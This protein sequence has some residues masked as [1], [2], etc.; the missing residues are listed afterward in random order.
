MVLVIGEA[1]TLAG[2]ITAKNAHP[3]VKVFGEFGNSKCSCRE[4]QAVRALPVRFSR[5]SGIQLVAVLGEESR[6]K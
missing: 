4:A 5:E 6:G 3:R 1:K 2:Q